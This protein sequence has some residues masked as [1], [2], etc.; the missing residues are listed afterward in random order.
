MTKVP[1]ENYFLKLAEH[2]ESD[3]DT[4]TNKRNRSDGSE[5]GN[6][7]KR[8][9]YD[10][11]DEVINL[12]DDAPVW[13]SA[14]LRTMNNVNAKVEETNSKI[15]DLALRFD[16][17]KSVID[18]EINTMKASVA[19]MKS[20]YDQ[21]IADITTS[22]SFIAAS[23]ETQKKTNEDL[24]A[25][26]VE[27]ERSQD[28]VTKSWKGE[29][30]TQAASIESA[31]QYSRRNC[32]L[33]HGVKEGEGE[34]TDA[35]VMATVKEHLA[36]SLDERDFDRSHRLGAPRKDGRPR[37]II[38]KFARY[39]T[40]AT[41]LRAKKRFKGTSFL[42]TESLTKRRMEVLNEARK[43]FGNRNVWTSDGEIFTKMEGKTVNVRFIQSVFPTV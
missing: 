8:I 30:C 36:I 29:L 31:E 34:N 10:A 37:P 6:S 20:E 22:A 26:M 43:Q 33:L 25:R 18:G 28:F 4:N 3:N 32:A 11:E 14:L 12:P 38:V 21:K 40:R 13:V 7:P 17:Y 2:T 35:L 27:L 23:F 24:L 1:I 16:N 19:D 41:V 42:L 15:E 39:N 9:V 5:A